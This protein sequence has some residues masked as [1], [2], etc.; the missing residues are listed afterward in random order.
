[1]LSKPDRSSTGQKL[2][3]KNTVCLQTAVRQF[4]SKVVQNEGETVLLAVSGGIDSMALMHAAQAIRNQ[5]DRAVRFVI[6]HVDHGLRSGESAED[7]KFVEA[8]VASLGLVFDCRIVLQGE[9][10]QHS[11]GSIE[12]SARKIRY[13]LLQEMAAEHSAAF[14]ATAHHADDQTETI[15]HNILRGTGLRGLHGMRPSRVLEDG[16]VLLR[17]MLTINQ[18]QI[19]EYAESHKLLFRC[20]ATNHDLS[21]TRNRI[22][23]EVLPMLQAQ[24]GRDVARSLTSLAAQANEA[25]EVIDQM[26]DEVLVRA[27]LELSPT[28]CRLDRSV[29]I[30]SSEFVVRHMLTQIWGRVGWPRQR[31]SSRH[32]IQL[33][34]M[35][36]N[37]QT[38]AAVDMPGGIRASVR[39]NLVC[40]NMNSE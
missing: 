10:D 9:V 29:L 35:I 18:K 28:I 24:S 22:R 1:M 40:L 20:D 38:S 8:A 4:F 30:S 26:S 16:I 2:M 21:F 39:N 17:P 37:G 36:M 3:T 12:E 11:R 19:R 25:M 23:H 7:R 6:G 32:W 31:M 34:T 5:T 13:R 15:L 33:S 14:I 27:Q